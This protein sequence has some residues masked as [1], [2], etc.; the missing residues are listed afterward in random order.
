MPRSASRSITRRSSPL[1]HHFT[2][3]LS[4]G[5]GRLQAIMGIRPAVPCFMGWTAAANESTSQ[6]LPNP[7]I[8]APTCSRSKYSSSGSGK[9]LL[10]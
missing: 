9:I 7:S 10:E 1:L 4:L 6:R 8:A 3:V 5:S 2:N